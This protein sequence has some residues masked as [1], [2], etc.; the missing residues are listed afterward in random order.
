MVVENTTGKELTFSVPEGYSV[1]TSGSGKKVTV[2]VTGIK[3]ENI[4]DKIKVTVSCDETSGYQMYSP[5]TYAYNRIRDKDR[6]AG[7]SK[8][9]FR[10]YT[11]AKK[12]AATKSE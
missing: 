10:Y 7:I 11:E 8:A 1:K 5:L 9:M 4:G 2:S 12:Y 3:A 6:E